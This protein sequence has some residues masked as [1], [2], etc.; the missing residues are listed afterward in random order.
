MAK[1]PNDP[2]VRAKPN[3]PYVEFVKVKRFNSGDNTTPEEIAVP[4]ILDA[5]SAHVEATAFAEYRK[6]AKVTLVGYGNLDSPKYAPLKARLDQ[7]LNQSD[8]VKAY[9]SG[10]Q[11]K[12]EK[13]K[14]N[15]KAK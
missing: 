3:F 2:T 6:Q 4:V 15:A 1:G 8:A 10:M 13:A 5:R 12:V 14:E 9:M 11:A 7:E